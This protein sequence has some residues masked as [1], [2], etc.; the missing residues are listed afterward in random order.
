M[1]DLCALQIARDMHPRIRLKFSKFKDFGLIHYAVKSRF[2]SC[3]FFFILAVI[4][5]YR[6]VPIPSF[7]SEVLVF[8]A[9]L[10]PMLL[11]WKQKLSSPNISFGI[12]LIA[13]IPLVQLFF[14]QIFFLQNAILPALFVCGA[15]LALSISY[16]LTLPLAAQP[17]PREGLMY[18]IAISL[19]VAGLISVVV[20]WIQW[21]HF[22]WSNQLVLPET[23]TQLVLHLVSDR[24][25]ANL[26]QPNL[27]ATLLLM[28]LLSLLYLF[29][30]QKIYSSLAV[31][32]SIVFLFT[33]SLTLSRTAW[34]ASFFIL[35]FLLL[36]AKP[37][38]FLLKRRY[39]LLW[40]AFFMA[41]F[42][43]LPQI[44]GFLSEHILHSAKFQMR[45]MAD[46]T[47]SGFERFGMWQQIF[48]AV[49]QKPWTGYGWY[50]TT[51]AQYAVA[52]QFPVHVWLTSAHN[53]VIDLLAWNGLLLGS[54][55]IGYLGYLFLLLF[56]KTQTVT[57]SCAFLIIVSVLLH[58][59]LEYPL[60]YANYLLP[61]ACMAG[62]ILAQPS[63][64]A[65]P[66]WQWPRWLLIVSILCAVLLMSITVFFYTQ[67]T[68]DR[69]PSGFKPTLLQS[70]NHWSL[71]DKIDRRGQ[72]VKL[73]T[74]SH[75]TDAEIDSYRQVVQCYLTHYDM[76]KFAQVLAFNGKQQEAQQIL[77]K[78]NSMYRK[79]HSYQSLLNSIDPSSAAK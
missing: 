23:S 59:L 32:L 78:I 49:L 66:A 20:A 64:T 43:L 1:G 11:F 21:L 30:K 57:A 31:L 45:S 36:K 16:S 5:P 34:L 69:L 42:W 56:K 72:R 17:Q 52:G 28:S 39:M 41:C 13:L 47:G 61:I 19:I 50:Q 63:K 54:L 48:A 51:A 2:L 75:L 40:F 6:Y 10:L 3:W 73:K 29:E 58:A 55:I 4:N 70:I 35:I 25:Y 77:D 8:C 79:K 74:N 14:G 67:P 22:D 12:L 44:N 76:Y 38:G 33:I 15:W 65:M 18:S 60:Y 46:R 62:V 7:V 53:I 24:P 71:F 37:Q 26:G 27:F 68:P 9:L